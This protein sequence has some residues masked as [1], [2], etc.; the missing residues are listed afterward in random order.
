[1]GTFIVI[2][3]S[4]SIDKVKTV[5]DHIYSVFTVQNDSALQHMDVVSPGKLGGIL[6]IALWKDVDRK[7]ARLIITAE[8]TAMKK[9]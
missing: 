9:V 8:N 6:D 1:M 3:I 5:T 7:V 2:C 4:L